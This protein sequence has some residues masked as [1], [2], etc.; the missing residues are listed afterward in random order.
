MAKRHH[1]D[2]ASEFPRKAGGACPTRTFS[3]FGRNWQTSRPGLST[4]QE[5]MSV[6]GTTIQLLLPTNRTVRGP[7]F[8]KDDEAVVVEYDC[9]ED[10]GRMRFIRLTF[11]EVLVF[12]Y[13]QAACFEASDVLPPTEMLCLH[14]SKRLGAVVSVWHESVGTQEFQA[15]RGGPERFRHYKLYF[16]DAGC[17]EVVASGLR[18]ASPT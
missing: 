8:R 10:D 5:A 11:M 16:D 12:E 2:H 7:T 4:R 1:E 15:I 9:E 6:D 13:R 17:I 14:H 18:Q 3:T